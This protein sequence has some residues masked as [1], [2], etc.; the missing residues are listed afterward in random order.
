MYYCLNVKSTCISVK[1]KIGRRLFT[2]TSGQV[3][4]AV[5]DSSIS[6]FSG[7]TSYIALMMFTWLFLVILLLSGMLEEQKDDGKC[8]LRPPILKRISGAIT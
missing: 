3:G 8:F 4:T 7:I 5:P 6:T 1:V 2:N